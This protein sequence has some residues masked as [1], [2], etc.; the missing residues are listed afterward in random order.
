M[1]NT[2]QK[3][4]NA[5]VDKAVLQIEISNKEEY[6][7]AQKLMD[8]LLDIYSCQRELI[9]RLSRSIKRWEKDYPE[10]RVSRYH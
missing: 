9:E 5:P 7:R 1:S 3:N 2:I 4:G 8:D 6:E 10:L